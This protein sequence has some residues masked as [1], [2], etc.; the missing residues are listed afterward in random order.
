VLV[1]ENETFCL[2]MLN[3]F[4]HSFDYIYVGDFSVSKVTKTTNLESSTTNF[5]GTPRIVA[6]EIWKKK[7]FLFLY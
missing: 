7:P 5:T 6:P 1:R 4:Y 2:C 3:N